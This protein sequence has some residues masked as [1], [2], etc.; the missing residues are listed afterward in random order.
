MNDVAGYRRHATILLRLA[1]EA[2]KHDRPDIADKLV[3]LAAVALERAEDIE[4][5]TSQRVV[6]QQQQP[7]PEPDK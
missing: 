4:C 5:G 7:Q 6:Q 3:Q 1:I 2:R